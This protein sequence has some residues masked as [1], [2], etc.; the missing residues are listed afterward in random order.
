[1]A[2]NTHQK[3]QLDIIPGGAAPVIHCSQGDVGRDFTATIYNSG[4][5]L[6]SDVD[7]VI[8][9][10]KPDKTVFE[11]ELTYDDDTDEVAFS[12][13]EQMTII[14]G[15]VECELVFSND[16]DIIASANF[17]LMVEDSPYNPDA[18]SESVI[19]G[20]VDLIED[21]IGGDIRDEVDA[22][23]EAH[24]ELMLQDNSVTTPKIAAGAVT[25]GKLA[26]NAVTTGKLATGAVTSAKVDTDFL[27]TIENAYVTP[28]QFGAVGDGTTDDTAAIQAAANV[29]G[30]IIFGKGKTYKITSTVRIKKNTTFDLN[31]ATIVCTDTHAFFNFLSS[32]TFTGYNGNG[33][34]IFRNGFMIGCA[35]SF[36]HARK[37][38]FYNLAFSDTLNDHYFEICACSDVVFRDCTF[39][40]MLNT[41]GGQYEY[42]NID[43]CTNS[44]FPWFSSTS[45]TYDGTPV[46]GLIVDNCAFYKNNTVMKDAVGKHSYYNASDYSDNP[47]KNITIRNCYVDGATSE[48]FRF[49]GADNVL[50]ESCTAENSRCLYY[51]S[52][53]T[54]VRVQGNFLNGNTDRNTISNSNRIQV[55]NNRMYFTSNYWDIIFE[56]TVDDVT[57]TGNFYK[58]TAGGRAPLATSNTTVTGLKIWGNIIENTSGDPTSALTRPSGTDTVRVSLA[59]DVFWHGGDERLEYTYDNMWV[60]DFNELVVLFGGVGAGTFALV[61]FSSYGGRNFL[62]GETFKAVVVNANNEP[63]IVSVTITSE[64]KLTFT[65][66]YARF[67]FGRKTVG[68]T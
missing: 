35:L 51:L 67:I 55:L 61:K 8:R 9:G 30:L 2:I 68:R 60:T 57:Y 42:I 53:C 16:G 62:V 59:D 20:I 3:F 49:L 23:I 18:P 12:T 19:P 39:T 25:E 43:N 38:R 27:K 28:E 48:A 14:S 63:T 52:Y 47:A 17:V 1:M 29:G 65:G 64:H 4:Y 26:S 40:G 7:V 45:T 58:N 54:D 56:G 44:N 34:I 33:D 22:L 36:I 6:P 41:S 11:Y 21:T 5:S 37:L 13:T 24:P 10:K 50:V 66:L 31:G 32:D 15:P 46:D